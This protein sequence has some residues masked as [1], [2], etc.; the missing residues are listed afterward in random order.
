MRPVKVVTALNYVT[1]G[2][3]DAN[4]IYD[5]TYDL[6]FP[7]STKE[8]YLALSNAYG[9]KQGMEGENWDYWK[10]VA[11]TATPLSTGA[12]HPEYIQYDLASP[13]TPRLCWERSANRGSGVNVASVHANGY[14]HNA[15]AYSGFRAAP[16]CAIG[17]SE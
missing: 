15:T 6:V 3:T 1:D 13:T 8:H 5:T 16:A 7:P 14:C 10:R 9:G 17:K 4:P 11:G 12:Y 2:G